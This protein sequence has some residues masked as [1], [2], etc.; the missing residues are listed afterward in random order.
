MRY[1]DDDGHSKICWSAILLRNP[2]W[3]VLELFQRG[4]V[5]EA[6]LPV[7]FILDVAPRSLG[8]QVVQGV[9]TD[10]GSYRTECRLFQS[11]H[12]IP[13]QVSAF[14]P[15]YASVVLQTGIL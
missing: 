5:L 2:L 6:E 12:G 15:L 14:V 13:S 11:T 10:E 9:E 3:S 4:A 1:R 8:F 7:W